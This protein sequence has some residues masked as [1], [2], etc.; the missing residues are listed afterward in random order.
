[1]PVTDGTSDVDRPQS[2]SMCPVQQNETDKSEIN[3]RTISNT[4]NTCAILK[5]DM[6]YTI[7]YDSRV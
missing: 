6:A 1:M 2:T 7:P 4:A 3:N 5:C